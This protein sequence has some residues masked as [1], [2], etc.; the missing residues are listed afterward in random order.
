MN[1]EADKGAPRL[2]EFVALMALMTSLGA[3]SIDAM[4]PALPD[5][6]GDLGVA[7]ENDSQLVISALFLGLAVGQM[8]YGPLSDSIGRKPA[9]YAGVVLF[10]AGCLM[11]IFAASFPEMLAGRVL[12]GFGVAGPRIVVVALI[13]DQYQG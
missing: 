2:G 7:H 10:I 13:R 9:I 4:L 1:S 12:Q 5:I 3:L 8:I 6:G 11:S